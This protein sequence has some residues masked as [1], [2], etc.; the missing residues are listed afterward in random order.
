MSRNIALYS[1]YARWIL[2]CLGEDPFV[3]G[4]KTRFYSLRARWS[5]D[6]GRRRVAA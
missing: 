5:R 3:E 2:I 4:L 1:A 6:G